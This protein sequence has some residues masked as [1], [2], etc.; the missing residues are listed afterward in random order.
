M[1]CPVTS[2]HRTQIAQSLMTKVLT[3][4]AKNMSSRKRERWHDP[5]LLERTVGG[6]A[7]RPWRVR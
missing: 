1:P 4:L 5:E 7:A 6:V 2:R 3:E